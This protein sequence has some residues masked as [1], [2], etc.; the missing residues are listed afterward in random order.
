[1]KA[2]LEMKEVFLPLLKLLEHSKNSELSG[3]LAEM[4]VQVALL[5]CSEPFLP[6]L[7]FLFL[8]QE[9]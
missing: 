5:H 6:F 8:I 1:M 2:E 9:K 7:Q 3:L 4:A